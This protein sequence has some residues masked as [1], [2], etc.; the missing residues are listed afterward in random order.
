MSIDI[1]N[2]DLRPKVDKH[3]KE[4]TVSIGIGRF[5]PDIM[6][7]PRAIMNPGRPLGLGN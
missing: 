3:I 5:Y 7:M 4:F 1:A 2:S 6:D